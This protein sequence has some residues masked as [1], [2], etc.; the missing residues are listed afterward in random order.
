MSRGWWL[1]LGWFALVAYWTW[2][3]VRSDR[4]FPS[5]WLGWLN[6]VLYLGSPLLFVVLL[7]FSALWLMT[8]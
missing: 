4:E 1:G 8:R 5:G 7:V 6:L 2:Q 3:L